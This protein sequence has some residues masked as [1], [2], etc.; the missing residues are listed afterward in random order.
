M[1]TEED[2]GETDVT[3]KQRRQ[4][5]ARVLAS[6]EIQEGISRLIL[7]GQSS[8]RQNAAENLCITTK[9]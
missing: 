7:I 2:R 4:M 5:I 1:G 6:V 9:Y 8:T 3:P